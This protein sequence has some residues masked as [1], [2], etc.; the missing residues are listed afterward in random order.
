MVNI[1]VLTVYCLINWRYLVFWVSDRWIL[2]E[3]KEHS[4]KFIF[5]FNLRLKFRLFTFGSR[6]C[7]DWEA[8]ATSLKKIRKKFQIFYLVLVSKV[9]HMSWK[10]SVVV[11]VNI[12]YICTHYKA[13]Y[14]LGSQI[15]MLEWRHRFE[16]DLRI[17][18]NHYL[19][20]GWMKVIVV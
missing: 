10:Y 12:K 7:K 6:N 5:I 16:F 4:K 19:F 18:F 1:D 15:G 2:A 17:L 20:S 8:W 11:D 9:Q 3:G 13:I 14:T